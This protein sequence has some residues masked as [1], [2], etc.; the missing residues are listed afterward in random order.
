MLS[1]LNSIGSLISYLLGLYFAI[2]TFY[3]FHFIQKAIKDNPRGHLAKFYKLLISPWVS[4]GL[5]GNEV[6][7]EI[8]LIDNGSRLI[9]PSVTY[10]RVYEAEIKPSYISFPLSEDFFTPAAFISFLIFITMSVEG[11]PVISNYFFGTPSQINEE[12]ISSF[13]SAKFFLFLFIINSIL[14][15]LSFDKPLARTFLRINKNEVMR[16]DNPLPRRSSSKQPFI[17]Q[18]ERGIL[19]KRTAVRFLDDREGFFVEVFKVWDFLIPI[20]L[21]D[22]PENITKSL[23]IFYSQVQENIKEKELD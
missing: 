12:S 21:R 17:A 19:F 13:A 14:G 20:I 9:S 22:T 11:Y 3:Q 18:K 2:I 7:E 6:I 16:L 15:K 4:S 8:P 10:K 1:F 5:S 23:N